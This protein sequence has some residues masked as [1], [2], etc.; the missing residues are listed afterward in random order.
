MS[1]D[2]QPKIGVDIWNSQVAPVTVRPPVAAIFGKGATSL[3]QIKQ[4]TD[5]LREHSRRL[6]DPARKGWPKQ[7]AVS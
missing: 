3:S 5:A 7:S 2:N 1:E 6:S 4:A